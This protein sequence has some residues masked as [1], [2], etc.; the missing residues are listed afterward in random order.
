MLITLSQIQRLENI[1]LIQD[2]NKHLIVSVTF[3][4][5]KAV[6][7]RNINLNRKILIKTI[8]MKAFN[9]FTTSP[10]DDVISN[11]SDNN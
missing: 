2:K 4:D 3:E 5:T 1:C 9:E 11:V 8:R 6:E 7:E 10:S